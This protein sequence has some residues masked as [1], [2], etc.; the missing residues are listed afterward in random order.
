ML[1]VR[2]GLT[3]NLHA[4]YNVLILAFSTTASLGTYVDECLFELQNII[5]PILS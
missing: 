5:V 2:T 3:F 1:L 4:E